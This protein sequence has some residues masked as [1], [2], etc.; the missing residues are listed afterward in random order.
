MAA[1]L[2][3]AVLQAGPSPDLDDMLR[4]ALA[5][6]AEFAAKSVTGHSIVGQE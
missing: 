4:V 1:G 5:A 3:S 2:F 6:G